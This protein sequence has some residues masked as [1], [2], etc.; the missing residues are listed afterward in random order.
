[1]KLTVIRKGEENAENNCM[2]CPAMVFSSIGR[3]EDDE[4]GG[5]NE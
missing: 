5:S 2:C 1:M 3:S 4:E